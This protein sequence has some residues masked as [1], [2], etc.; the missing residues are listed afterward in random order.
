M[1]QE[2]AARKWE[3]MQDDD[4]DN[5]TQQEKTVSQKQSQD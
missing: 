2:Q 4:E 1:N 5:S 3:D